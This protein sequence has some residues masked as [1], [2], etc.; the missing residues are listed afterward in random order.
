M[1]RPFLRIAQTLER[2]VS[3]APA[4]RAATRLRTDV[5]GVDEWPRVLA[6]RFRAAALLGPPRFPWR[7]QTRTLTLNFRPSLVVSSL[8]FGSSGSPGD[9]AHVTGATR[10]IDRRTPGASVSVLDAMRQHA[11]PGVVELLANGGSAQPV[12]ARSSTPSSGLTRTPSTGD[13]FWPLW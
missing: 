1:V 7:R 6:R 8:G 4:R 11:D 2:V 5:V 12:V 10:G 9:R 13:E 3:A